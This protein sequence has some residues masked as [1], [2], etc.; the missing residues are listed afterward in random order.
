MTGAEEQARPRVLFLCTGNSCR[1]QMAE[2]WLRQLCGERFECLSAGT[3]SHGVSPRAVAAM[4]AAGVDISG[5]RSKT[6]DEFLQAP[7]DLVIT[8]CDDAARRCPTLSAATRVLHWPFPDP[9]RANGGE[10][11]LAAVFAD[12]RDRIRRRITAWLESGAPLE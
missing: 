8:V 9:A 3:E 5:Q 11:E 7:P 10:E 12:V 4:R 1:S 2:G 6:I